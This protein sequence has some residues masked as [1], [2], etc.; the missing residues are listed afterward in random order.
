MLGPRFR[1][2]PPLPDRALPLWAAAS[3]AV[4]VAVVAS[5]VAVAGPTFTADRREPFV[6]IEVGGTSPR[7][8]ALPPYAASDGGERGRDATPPAAPPAPG[9]R[10]L[11]TLPADTLPR[12]RIPFSPEEIVLV[13]RPGRPDETAAGLGDIEGELRTDR[14]LGPAYG[15]GRLWV[16]PFIAQL[17][18]V[19]PSG[20]SLT[21]YARVDSAVRAR[22]KAFIDTMPSDSFALP[23]APSWTTELGGNTWGIDEQWIYLG[24]L[25]IP[26]AL[27][28]LI[29]FP[30]GNYDQAKAARELQRMRE[31]IIQAAR[32]AETMEEFRKYVDE[33]RQRKDAEREAARAARRDTVVPP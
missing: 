4:H 24:D 8:V 13:V 6:L 32:R 23:A 27:L 28:A 20:D 31:D 2:P 19:G 26:T 16:R 1:V 21:H 17:G 7:E 12:P 11:P 22:M 29:P 3:V 30:Q 18:V 14:V 5:L 9:A 10:A 15:D 33:L 25:K